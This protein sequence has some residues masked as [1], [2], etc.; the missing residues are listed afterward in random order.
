VSNTKQKKQPQ[1][2]RKS[3]VTP[4]DKLLEEAAKDLDTWESRHARKLETLMRAARAFNEQMGDVPG[5][6]EH[7]AAIRWDEDGEGVYLVEQLDHGV[8]VATANPSGAWALYMDTSALPL[9]IDAAQRAMQRESGWK[10]KA[11][12]EANA[13]LAHEAQELQEVAE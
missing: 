11:E 1:R 10:A 9:V 3:S 2:R 7:H 6:A 12:S 13:L 4:P 5:D 8:L